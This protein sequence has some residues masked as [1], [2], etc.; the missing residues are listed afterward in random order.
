MEQAF[1]ALF[2]AISPDFFAGAMSMDG[3][4]Q[5][6]G[7]KIEGGYIADEVK[8]LMAKKS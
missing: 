3:W 4:L 1:T 6:S 2:D 8:K 7:V 5:F